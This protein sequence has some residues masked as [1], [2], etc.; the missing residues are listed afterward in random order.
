MHVGA[1]REHCWSSVLERERE[2]G[3]QD[4]HEGSCV[5]R[6]TGCS[7]VQTGRRVCGTLRVLFGSLLFSQ[8]HGASEVIKREEIQKHSGGLRREAKV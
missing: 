5:D 3:I 8:G 2:F 7:S 4:A 1:R 6:S